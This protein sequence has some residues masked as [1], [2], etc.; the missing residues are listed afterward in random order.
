MGLEIAVVQLSKS[1]FEQLVEMYEHFEPKRAA[2]GLPPT[3]RDRI[4]SWLGTTPEKR[5]EFGGSLSGSS[6]RPYDSLRG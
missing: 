6:D 3:G 2:Q 4:L 1:N 5:G